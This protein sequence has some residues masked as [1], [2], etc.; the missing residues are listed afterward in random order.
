MEKCDFAIASVFIVSPLLLFSLFHRLANK[1]EKKSSKIIKYTF[2][3]IFMQYY[4]EN[5]MKHIGR[6]TG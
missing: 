5:Y 1:G 4:N 6:W 3:F 2:D